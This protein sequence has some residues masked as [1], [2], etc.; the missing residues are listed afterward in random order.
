MR[1]PAPRVLAI[2]PGTVH[3][4]VAVLEAEALIHHAVESVKNRRSPHE[5]LSAC[6]RVVL[7][8]LRDFRPATIACERTFFANNRNAALLNVLSDEIC[9]IARQQR[10]LFVGLAPS[11]V[12][13]AVTGDGSADKGAVATAVAARFPELLGYL[14]H[15]RKSTSRYYSNMFDA[16]ALALAVRDRGVDQRQSRASKIRRQAIRAS[17]TA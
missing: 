9:E 8:L 7:R 14:A 17:R 6:R 4:G 12:K 13:R 11:T 2:D 1:H 5:I 15:D 16:V 3:M 10:I